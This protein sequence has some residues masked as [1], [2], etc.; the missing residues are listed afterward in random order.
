MEE[1]FT[2][3]YETSE[4]G[5]NNN[6]EYNGSSGSG[7]TIDFN[8][9]TYIPFIKKFIHDHDIK[10]VVDLGCGDFQCGKLIYDDLYVQYNGYDVYKKVI[11]YNSKI[12][13]RPKYSFTHLD[14]CNNVESIV[15]AELCIIKDVLQHWSLDNIYKFLDYLV[16]SK[17][18]KYILITNCCNQSCD[19]SEIKDGQW[20]QLSCDFLPLKKYNPKK[21]Y[22]YSTKEVS[23]I[24][25]V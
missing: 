25:I 19:N 8:R 22:K 2:R 18:F 5:N 11:E 12:H 23:V 13:P 6:K 3:V 1:A 10:S 16:T 9:S 21:L 4:W 17:K 7:S 24:E 15:N 20:R 14:F